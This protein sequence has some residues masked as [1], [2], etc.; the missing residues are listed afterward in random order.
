MFT[1]ILCGLD[2]SLLLLS[3]SNVSPFLAKAVAMPDFDHNMTFREHLPEGC[4]PNEAEEIGQVRVVFRLVRT[5]PPTD[6]DFVSQRAEKPNNQFNVSECR[7]RGLSVFSEAREAEKQLKL[8]PLRAML[9]CQLTL[10]A[11]AGY[12][13]RTGRQSHFTWWPLADYYVL[14]NCQIVHP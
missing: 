13:F 4:P 11:G 12:M 9:I 2:C 1:E 6:S 7:A 14:D 10:D 3:Y 5:D 8:R